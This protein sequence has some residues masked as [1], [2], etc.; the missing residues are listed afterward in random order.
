M[1]SFFQF[2]SFALA[3]LRLFLHFSQCHRRRRHD[4]AVSPIFFL[5]SAALIPFFFSL[6]LPRSVVFS[7]YLVRRGDYLRPLSRRKPKMKPFIA[8]TP[9]PEDPAAGKI[10]REFRLR[11]FSA[12]A[13]SSAS[14]GIYYF[15]YFR[16]EVLHFSFVRKVCSSWY[17]IL[18]IFVI[19]VPKG[20][21][22][23]EFYKKLPLWCKNRKN[24]KLKH[25]SDNY[26]FLLYRYYTA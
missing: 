26:F 8:A 1:S 3:L 18:K 6:S 9:F 20:V 4:E 16:G 11:F 21:Y 13:E 10:E 23:V 14:S 7:S 5:V 17:D 24:S 19:G 25:T 15:Y 12:H 2:P 22:Y